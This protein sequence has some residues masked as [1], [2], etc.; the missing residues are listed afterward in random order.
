MS[1]DNSRRVA[2]ATARS[3]YGRLLSILAARTRD[4]AGA[5][6]ALAEA[7]ATAL[8]VWPERG[9]P[10]NPSAWLL[11]TAR[12]QVGAVRRHN[13]VKANAETV[14][15]M[16]YDELGDRSDNDF[17][18]ERLRLL[19]VCA[20]PAIDVNI[21]SA[22]MLQ[23]VLGLNADRIGR[24]FLIPGQTMGQRLVRA[25]SRVRDA[26]IPFETPDPEEMPERLADVLE[27]IYGAFGVGWDDMHDYIETGR[28]LVNEALYL[29]RLVTSAL[30]DEPEP[31]GLLAL[32]LY[33]EAR[34]P[35]RLDESGHFVPLS[36]QDTTLWRQPM[37]L[38][39]EA[40]L[41]RAAAFGQPG[42]FQTEAAIQSVYAQRAVTGVVNGRAIIKLYD[43]LDHLTGTIGAA[44]GR[45]VAHADHGDAGEALAI[46]NGLPGR[47]VT[48]HQPYWVA[49]AHVLEVLGR[50]IEAS[51]AREKAIAL[52]SD[53]AQLD[54]LMK[55][56]RFNG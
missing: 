56:R 14:I 28:D 5:E 53:P 24:A 17:K 40:L 4:I 32:M 48:S 20:H 1:K 34:R 16:I 10:D 22:L 31:K 3:S 49:Q 27:A 8:R 9:V 2:E 42:R 13:V 51:E 36:D 25:K 30:P 7:F 11:T 26:G 21:R 15:E 50:K 54:F 38:E 39:A 37:I 29:A 43:Y 35:A 45:A 6:D 41:Q 52:T 55:Q 47:A 18:D 33:C 23:S 44:L 12:R 46:L 19:F